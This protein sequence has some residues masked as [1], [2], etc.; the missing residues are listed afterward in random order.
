M[1][2]RQIRYVLVLA[3]HQ[4]FTKAAAELSI[5]QPALSTQISLTEEELG[6]K[7][8]NR[9]TRAVTLT[10]AGEVFCEKANELMRV[11]DDMI[12]SLEAQRAKTLTPI[13]LGMP[14]RSGHSSP[15]FT[16]CMDFFEDHP[17]YE[18]SYISET[19]GRLLSMTYQGEL[20]ATLCS[21][22]LEGDILKVASELVTV[23]LMTEPNCAV[24]NKD[25]FLAG[26]ESMDLA[27]L[28]GCTLITGPEDSPGAVLLDSLTKELGLEPFDVIH[29]N[30][31]DMTV[32]LV[33]RNEGIAFAPK[34]VADYYG[35]A[36]V[37]V[38]NFEL[39]P[40]GIVYRAKD[41]DPI[42]IQLKDYLKG[43][44]V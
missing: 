20:A 35:L 30:G 27:D 26:R 13:K 34:A 16:A 33:R 17:D 39:K 15:A 8:F 21:L 9:T 19:D 12:S 22:P 42:L 25:H 43:H 40:M 32:H 28:Q 3:R 1:D 14:L 37:P 6:V 10:E 2:I 5:T 4:Q 7:L 18:V 23:P 31:M 24:M 44:L 38:T 36:A 11:W 29:T 41:P